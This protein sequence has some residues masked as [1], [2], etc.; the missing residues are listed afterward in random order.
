[1]LSHTL[2]MKKTSYL[3]VAHII[4]SSLVIIGW[5]PRFI[6][7][8]WMFIVV[9]CLF[10]IPL[11]ENII[12]FVSSIPFFIALPITSTFDSLNAWRIVSIVI[13]VRWICQ[14]LTITKIIHEVRLCLKKPIVYIQQ[15]YGAAICF[16]LLLCAIVSLIHASDIAAGI[17]RIVYFI[18]L[19]LVPIVLWDLLSH[20]ESS[21]TIFNRIIRSIY[22]PVILVTIA[23]FIQ[24]ISTYFVDIYGFVH[25]W[26][27]VI[28][29]NLF[30]SA[31]SYIAIHKG[32][33]WF[34]YFG[35]QLSLRMFS[36]F[37]DSHSFPIFLLLGLPAVLTVNWHSRWRYLSI[38]AILLAALLTG[39]RGIWAGSIIA[40]LWCLIL[41]FFVAQHHIATRDTIKK[42]SY[43]ILIFF[44][45]FLIAYPI[46]ASPQFRLAKNHDSLIL[47]RLH[48]IIEFGETSNGQRILIWKATLRAIVRHPLVGVGIYNFP[49]ILDQDIGLGKAGSSAHNIY[50][51]VFAEM[52]IGAFLLALLFILLLLRNTRSIMLHTND[53][54][55]RVYFTGLLITLVWIFAYL[56]TDVAL[57]DERTFLLFGITVACIWGHKKRSNILR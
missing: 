13:F 5:I 31:W 21:N 47:H 19:S 55:E 22:I 36:L 14:K 50:L 38:P 43:I 53:P 39:T 25:V 32:N 6:I 54:G 35:D 29:R 34:A 42:T 28:D 40:G 41:Y 15:H 18:N 2:Y 3:I 45:L 33:T 9:S 30:G 24:L 57:F 8:P 4:I 17:K 12:F 51:H 37:P 27:E 48:S 52:G 44:S 23:G 1:M 49:T 56:M 10:L 26:G 11:E 16:G 46:F 7:V 20:R